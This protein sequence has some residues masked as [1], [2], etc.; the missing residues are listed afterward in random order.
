MISS[1]SDDI[2]DFLEIS[3]YE[4]TFLETIF[5]DEGPEKNNSKKM[6][7]VFPLSRV[8]FIEDS[9]SQTRFQTKQQNSVVI[10]I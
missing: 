10:K 8:T 2:C 5:S 6:R 3:K 7:K 4:R 9:S 1:S